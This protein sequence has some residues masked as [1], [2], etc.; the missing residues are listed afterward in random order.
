[1]HIHKEKMKTDNGVPLYSDAS[2]ILSKIK[3]VSGI[4]QKKSELADR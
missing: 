1:M 2:L 4:H 3:L